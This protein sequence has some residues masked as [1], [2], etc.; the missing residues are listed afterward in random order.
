MQVK[1]LTDE[2]VF[3]D[4]FLCGKFTLLVCT[5]HF[6]NFSTRSLNVSIQEQ[7]SILCTEIIYI[8]M[9]CLQSR[10]VLAQWQAIEQLV[11]DFSQ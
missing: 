2:Q 7:T 3:Y 11:H 8:G 1:A 4:K 9:A 6:A 5:S 10:D